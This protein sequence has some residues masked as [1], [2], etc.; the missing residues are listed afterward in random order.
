MTGR[1]LY[2]QAIGS[3]LAQSLEVALQLDGVVWSLR[4]ASEHVSSLLINTIESNRI[5]VIWSCVAPTS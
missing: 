1:V 4:R 2:K 5:S 3:F